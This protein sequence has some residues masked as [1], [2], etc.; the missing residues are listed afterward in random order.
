MTLIPMPSSHHSPDA[1]FVSARL[2]KRHMREGGWCGGESSW[3]VIVYK[4]AKVWT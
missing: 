2:L 1:F 3:V 4:E